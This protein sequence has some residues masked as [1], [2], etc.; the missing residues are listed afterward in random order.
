MVIHMGPI[1]TD[2][3]VELISVAAGLPCFQSTPESRKA[4][5]ALYLA[6][7]VQAV[8][9]KEIPSADVTVEGE[10]IVVA[11]KGY[12]AEGKKMLAKVD[13][14]IDAEKSGAH[15]KVRLISR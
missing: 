5:D 13:Q 11:C 3:A 2:Q 4:M 1:T 7:Q 15:I 12:W 14:I 6:A 10:E 8:L 9:V